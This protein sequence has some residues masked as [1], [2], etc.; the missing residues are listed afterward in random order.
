M[1]K[2]RTTAAFLTALTKATIL[3]TAAQA[4]EPEVFDNPAHT[5][6]YVCDQTKSATLK[7]GIDFSLSLSDIKREGYTPEKF[8]K[9]MAPYIRKLSAVWHN[10][11][12]DAA[13]NNPATRDE[14]QNPTGTMAMEANRAIVGVL[15]EIENG[16]GVT[17]KINQRLEGFAVSLGGDVKCNIP[18]KNVPAIN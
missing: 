12:V 1:S 10:A 15:Q 7:I 14:V 17:I 11:W 18:K 6:V 2:V 9:V 3:T 16:T 5:H 13:S 8:G 4:Q